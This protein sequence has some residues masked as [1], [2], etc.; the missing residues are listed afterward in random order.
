[1]VEEG[2][3]TVEPG[4]GSGDSGSTK[5]LMG[6]N[7]WPAWRTILQQKGYGN[8]IAMQTCTKRFKFGGGEITTA[9]QCCTF[10]IVV[11][12]KARQISVYLVPGDT[13]MLTARPCFEQSGMVTD[14]PDKMYLFKEEG[15]CHDAVQEHEDHFIFDLLE[16]LP[17]LASEAEEVSYQQPASGDD[18]DQEMD[19]GVPSRAPPSSE[20]RSD[21]S[22]GDTSS[23]SDFD[24]D[25][26]LL[27]SVGMR[28]G[29][30]AVSLITPTLVD[31]RPLDDKAFDEPLAAVSVEE[32]YLSHRRRPSWSW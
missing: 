9:K 5:P 30:A 21:E 24:V 31:V 6:L 19:E 20:E 12:G 17:Q 14:W 18:S 32:V 4:K 22:D 7:L 1:M 29:A 27:S 13:P 2:C 26:A 10:P 25:D 16:G 3:L 15:V 8:Q 28:S 23:E 11:G